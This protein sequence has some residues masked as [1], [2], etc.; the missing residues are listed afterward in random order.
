M[1]NLALI[2]RPTNFSEVL[3]QETTIAQIV[4]HLK[5]IV[6]NPEDQI[7]P[8]ILAGPRGT[9]KTSTGRLIAQYLNCVNERNITKTCDCENCVTIR[10]NPE[11]LYDFVELDGATHNGV[12][13]VEKIIENT[14]YPPLASFRIVLIDEAH[15]LTR[16]AFNSLLKQLEEPPKRVL[17]IL[18][19]TEEHKLLPTVRSRCK[20]RRFG[21]LPDSIIKENIHN[22]VNNQDIVPSNKTI[23]PDVIDFIVSMG[24]GSM[25]DAIKTLGEI[26]DLDEINLINAQKAAGSGD[27]KKLGTLLQTLLKGE[28]G[29]SLIQLHKIEKEGADPRQIMEQLQFLLSDCLNVKSKADITRTLPSTYYTEKFAEINITN[30]LAT[31]AMLI[32]IEGVSRGNITYHTLTYALVA[33]YQKLAKKEKPKTTPQIY[34][35]SNYNTSI[36][37]DTTANK[38]SQMLTKTQQPTPEAEEEEALF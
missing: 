27:L 11:G 33:A 3:G 4:N 12:G 38:L 7:Q 35:P 8:I 21:L 9:G 32:E 13:E 16:N 30:V 23:T 20:M 1:T 14:F 19:T 25:R 18:A 34:P 31:L 15:M 5:N 22:I 10:D 28:V 26:L 6:E 2:T 29:P 36:P 37:T 24:R 17:Y